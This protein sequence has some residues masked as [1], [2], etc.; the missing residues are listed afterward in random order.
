MARFATIVS[1]GRYLPEI[2]VS[3]DVLRERFAHGEE[4]R[5]EENEHPDRWLH[6]GSLRKKE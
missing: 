5:Q 3:N 4:G 2:E 1:T 6:T